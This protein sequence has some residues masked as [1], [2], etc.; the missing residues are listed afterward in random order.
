MA[1]Y[2]TTQLTLQLFPFYTSPAAQYSEVQ[3]NEYKYDNNGP[4]SYY[5][6][7]PY[8]PPPANWR[9]PHQSPIQGMCIHEQHNTYWFALHFKFRD[10]IS[11]KRIS[12]ETRIVG[13]LE[14][15]IGQIKDAVVRK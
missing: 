13:T 10:E 3:H 6:N 2:S 12:D 14:V 11:M 7:G 9:P 1:C 8:G 5:N 4:N 15:K